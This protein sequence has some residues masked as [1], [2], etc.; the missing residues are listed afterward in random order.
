VLTL[1]D[2]RG[3][4]VAPFVVQA[5][6]VHD[7]KLFDSSFNNLLEITDELGLDIRGSY[8]TLD[9]GFDSWYNKR[10]IACRNL[11]PVI[12]P[13]IR[14]L[15]NQKKTNQLLDEFE[16]LKPIYKQRVAIERCFAW[17]DAYRKLVIRYEKLQSTFMGFRYLAYSMINFR[18]FFTIKI[19]I[20]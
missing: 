20:E 4:I 15:Q 7:I 12:K 6:N 14:R 13:N 9:S 1:A 11:I 5:V 17:E 19:R 18:W 16:S 2:N 10:E 3:N 8:L